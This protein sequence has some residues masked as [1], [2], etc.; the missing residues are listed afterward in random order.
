[1]AIKRIEIGKLK[2]D[3]VLASP[4]FFERRGK[5]VLLMNANTYIASEHQKRKI[6][7]A[8]VQF[9]DIDTD[10]G[11]DTF[12]SLDRQKKWSEMKD[13]KTDNRAMDQ[14]MSR[15]VNN[16]I[17]AVTNTIMK[18]PTSRMLINDEPA[19]SIVKEIIVFIEK[20]TDAL[21][22]LVRLK[23]A[24]EYIFTHSVNTTV[25]CISLAN[26]LGFKYK[27]ILRFAKGTFLADVGMTSFPS[28]MISR[29]SGLS[30]KEI[31]EIKK[32]PIY[33]IDFLKK[34]N[35]EDNLIE[36]IVIQHHERF[37]GSGY[38]YGL[39]GDEIHPISKLFAIVDVY[40]AM[41]SSRP[42]R[43]GIPPHIVLGEIHKL[44][45]THFDPKMKDYFIKQIGIF[46]IGNLVELTSGHVGIVA[47]TNKANPLKPTAIVFQKTRKI[48]SKSTGISARH[49]LVAMS[50]G[51]WEVVDLSNA[52]E[53][54]GQIKRGLDHR[55]YGLKPDTY[56]L[57][58]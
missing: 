19:S 47:S 45:G 18:N 40:V 15:H 30:K 6:I 23:A 42:Q 58:I 56:L 57:Q 9:V 12:T 22:S 10:K 27:D 33:A 54:I 46:P 31:D 5:S 11:I 3:M 20:N 55:E 50:R 16:F 48:S 43:P 26:S 13:D 39:Q 36:I 44:S 51:S 34:I 8:G 32:H 7:D 4:V 38:P 17:S 35:I 41:T 37:D 52:D 1:M 29:A 2:V 14:L 53:S 28:K 49:E 24:N 25:L 21:L